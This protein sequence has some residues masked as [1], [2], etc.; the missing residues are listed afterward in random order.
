MSVITRDVRAQ[1]LRLAEFVLS[2]RAAHQP[3]EHR[4]R[5]GLPGRILDPVLLLEDSQSEAQNL[6]RA[7]GPL[8]AIAVKAF[9]F[10][11][12]VEPY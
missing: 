11:R 12:E 3:L 9:N 10:R 5:L 7:I 2:L 6:R 8:V 4:R 1:T